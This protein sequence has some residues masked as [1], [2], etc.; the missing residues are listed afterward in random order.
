MSRLVYGLHP[1]QELLH[2]RPQQ[3]QLLWLLEPRGSR[4]HSLAEFKRQVKE[5]GIEV[6]HATREQLDAFCDTASHQ[7]VVAV[8]GEFDYC[9]LEDLVE[10]THPS[11]LLVAADG[12]TDPQNL[13]AMIR[14]SVVLGATGMVV[15][16]DRSSAITPTV[17]RVSSGATEHLRCAMVI[18]L[19]RALRQLK[20][21]GLWVT[22]AVERGGLAPSQLALTEPTVLVLGNEQRGIRPNVLKACDQLVTIP[23][24]GPIGALNVAAATSVLLYEAARQRANR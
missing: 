7:G 4:R 17:V 12:I 16:K 23:T 13:G 3:I 6:R 15:P 2:S 14:S 1:V 22:G 10:S 8:V 20:Q 21:A 24:T 18:N 11:P 9:A 5:R 19:A